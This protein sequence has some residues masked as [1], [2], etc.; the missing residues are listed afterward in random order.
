MSGRPAPAEHLWRRPC[1]SDA[2]SS[3][4]SDGVHALRAVKR[5]HVHRYGR[6]RR[7]ACLFWDLSPS[8]TRKYVAVCLLKRAHQG[9]HSYSPKCA[10]MF[11]THDI[12]TR[13]ACDLLH[14]T[15]WKRG[16]APH[17]SRQGVQICWAPFPAHSG[18]LSLSVVWW[19]WLLSRCQGDRARHTPM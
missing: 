17:V 14:S 12:P 7:G 6:V 10:H 3:A 8:S 2:D 4:G 15:P 9:G 16:R 18:T 19:R 13:T 5:S 1:D 11:G